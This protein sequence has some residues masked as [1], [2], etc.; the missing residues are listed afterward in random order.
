MAEL[1]KVQISALAGSKGLTIRDRT[2]PFDADGIG[3]L[4]PEELERV[5]SGSY[6]AQVTVIGAEN[7]PPGAPPVEATPP[8]AP[9]SEETKAEEGQT[10]PGA[11]PVDDGAQT[12]EESPAE[13][14]QVQAEPEGNPP[15]TEEPAAQAD[16][17]S[18][19]PEE[20]TK[21]EKQPKAG[22]G[23]KKG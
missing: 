20:P 22:K 1:I 17:S 18:K 8:E 3:E 12:P 5:S 9:P 4:T 11:D 10:G 19:K 7:G 13:E 2:I 21:P 14:A 16:E 6:F 15:K 23:G